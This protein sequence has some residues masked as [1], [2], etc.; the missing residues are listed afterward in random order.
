MMQNM[1]YLKLFSGAVRELPRFAALAQAVLGQADDFISLIPSLLAAFSVD[2][3]EGVQLDLLGESLGLKRAMARDDSDDSYR[4][5]I[6]AKLA[7]WRWD[8]TNES[9][10]GLLEEAFPGQEVRMRDNGDMTVT[11]KPAQAELVLPVAAGVK[12]IDN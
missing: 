11:V 8:G 9:V 10:P 4:D 1:D 2:T 7:L 6:K 12:I 5:L 3:A